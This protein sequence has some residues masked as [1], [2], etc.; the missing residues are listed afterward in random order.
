MQFSLHPASLWRFYRGEKTEAQRG[1]GT[2]AHK[3]RGRALARPAGR[4]FPS[5]ILPSRSH[6]S[7]AGTSGPG[8]SA[9]RPTVPP[10]SCPG[11]QPA[12]THQR[13]GGKSER[14]LSQRC[15]RGT[16]QRPHDGAAVQETGVLP[17]NVSEDRRPGRRTLGGWDSSEQSCPRKG[18]DPKGAERGR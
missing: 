10:G 18:L 14:H 13:V 5:N 9:P 12:G 15:P 16:W 6:F 2:K 4:I 3:A 11:R 17:D 8:F 1:S 7:E